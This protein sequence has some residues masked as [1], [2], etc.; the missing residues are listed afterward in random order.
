MSSNLKFLGLFQVNQRILKATQSWLHFTIR[1]YHI[2]FLIVA[3]VNNSK[4]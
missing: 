2:P 3:L 4:G 1:I